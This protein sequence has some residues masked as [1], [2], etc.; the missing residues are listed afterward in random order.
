VT[1]C[2]QSQLD[3]GPRP[4]TTLTQDLPIGSICPY[5]M[6]DWKAEFAFRQILAVTLVICVFRRLE[7]HIV[8]PDLEVDGDE[9]DEWDA[10]SGDVSSAGGTVK[11]AGTGA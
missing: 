1:D 10:I 11:A 4:I 7:I 5:A 2:N 9:V 6:Y 8:V 3:N